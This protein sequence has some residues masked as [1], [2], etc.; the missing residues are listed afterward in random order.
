MIQETPLTRYQKTKVRS[1]P[2]NFGFNYSK[3][4]LDVWI[5][6]FNTPK[7]YRRPWQ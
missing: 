2:S 1:F 6:L 3:K 7:D 5:P 4:S